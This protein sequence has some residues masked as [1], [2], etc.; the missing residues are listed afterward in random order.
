M[1]KKRK[2]YTLHYSVKGL[3]ACDPG[4][5]RELR[6]SCEIMKQLAVSDPKRYRAV[7]RLA[8]YVFQIRLKQVVPIEPVYL[9]R[10]KKTVTWP[11]IIKS[12]VLPELSTVQRLKDRYASAVEAAINQFRVEVDS[13]VDRST[14]ADWG[15]SATAAAIHETLFGV[16]LVGDRGGHY[17]DRE[18]ADRSSA[19]YIPYVSR[20]SKGSTVTYEQTKGGDPYGRG[21]ESNGTVLRTERY[22]ENGKFVEGSGH[23]D[24][25]AP[26]DDKTAAYMEENPK[27]APEKKEPS[28]EQG[29][30]YNAAVV[31]IIMTLAVFRPQAQ[32]ILRQLEIKGGTPVDAPSRRKRGNAWMRQFDAH[33]NNYFKKIITRDMETR[34]NKYGY[35]PESPRI[36]GVFV[37]K[38]VGWTD[39][40]PSSLKIN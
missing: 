39:P 19:G 23:G 15:S 7:S 13:L 29:E 4:I 22:D 16:H 26:W 12:A 36:G 8:T 32:E 5:G 9:K 30:G 34:K 20:D 21:E 27:E 14:G 24:D 33:F 25:N 6:Q 1:P 18:K 11:H 17:G 31:D 2:K 35:R 28:P 3:G 40:P 38:S 10:K 37:V